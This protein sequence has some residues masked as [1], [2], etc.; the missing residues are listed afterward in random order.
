MNKGQFEVECYLGD[1]R[2]SDVHMFY[3]S[4]YLKSLKHTSELKDE[5]NYLKFLKD[6]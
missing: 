3:K 4:S 5:K 6:T 1:A 2:L